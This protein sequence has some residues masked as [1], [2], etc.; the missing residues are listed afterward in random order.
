MANTARSSF[1]T[2]SE[3]MHQLEIVAAEAGCS[4]IQYIEDGILLSLAVAGAVIENRRAGKATTLMYKGPQEG[5]FDYY[6]VGRMLTVSEY[7]DEPV[8]DTG[9]ADPFKTD[10]VVEL[11]IEPGLIARVDNVCTEL[12]S[13]RDVFVEASI[14]FRLLLQVANSTGDLVLIESADPSWSYDFS[15]SH[16]IDGPYF[17]R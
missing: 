17:S 12:N 1:T 2:N 15:T 13:E 6:D 8:E 16:V 7:V 9:P 10:Q 11:D 4:P 14:D 3:S 5:P